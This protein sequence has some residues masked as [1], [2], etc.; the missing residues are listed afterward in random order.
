MS[1]ITY[2]VILWLDHRIQ[3]K[4]MDPSVTHWDDRKEVYWNDKGRHSDDNG[5]RWDNKK[6]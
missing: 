2:F 1:N 6:N 5:K 4:E 3:E